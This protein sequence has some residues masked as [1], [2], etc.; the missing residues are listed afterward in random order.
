MAELTKEKKKMQT[1]DLIVAGAF[2]ALYTVLMFVGVSMLGFIPILYLCAPMIIAF[3]LGPIFML[4][5]VKVPKRG[6]IF[7][8]S[9]L[10]GLLTSMGGVWQAGLW[11]LGIGLVAELIAASGKYQ[12]KRRYLISYIVFACTNMGPFWM[13]V[14]AKQAFLDVCQSYY[15]ADYVVTIDALTPEWFILVLIGIALLGGLAGGLFGQRLI[16]KHFKKAGVV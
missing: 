4:Y 10:V 16:A 15:G 13:L 7:I 2:A 3:I 9:I 5:V 14:F 6:A 1:K 12:S 8:L 11:S